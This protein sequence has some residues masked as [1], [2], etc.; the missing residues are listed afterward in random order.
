MSRE[1]RPKEYTLLVPM[2]LIAQIVRLMGITHRIESGILY[3]LDAR[4]DLLIAEC[5]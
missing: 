1:L 5:M 3:L 2:L 4:L